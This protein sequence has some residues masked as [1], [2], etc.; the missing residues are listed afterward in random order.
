MVV[1]K[2]KTSWAFI[3]RPDDNGNYRIA[4]TLDKEQT[5]ALEA[6]LEK[7]AQ[8]NGKSKDKCDWFGSKKVDEATGDIWFSA[9]CKKEFTSKSGE[10]IQREL[11]VYDS[12]AKEMSPIPNVANG[13]VCN[14]SISPY[15]VTYLKKCGVMLNL[16]SVQLLSYEE[17]AG[18]NPFEDES[19]EFAVE[20][21]D[22]TGSSTDM[23]DYFK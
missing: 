9:K 19:A 6:E 8:E 23:T 18:G 10:L 12:R 14:I 21:P 1:K 20:I 11:K 7:V 2:A 22:N 15:F 4:F 3:S 17:Y 16:N 5:Q 13:A